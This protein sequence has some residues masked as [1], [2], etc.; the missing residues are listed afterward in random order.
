ML[1]YWNDGMLGF[2]EMGTWDIGNIS[3]N[4]KWK[5]FIK[6]TNFSNNQSR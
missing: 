2:G 1:E 5:V 3:L 6:K 4:R